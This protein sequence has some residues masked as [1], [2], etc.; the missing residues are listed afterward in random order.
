[1]RYLPWSL[2]MFFCVSS[3]FADKPRDYPI[4]PVPFTAVKVGDGFWLPRMTTSRS[5]FGTPSWTR[6]TTSTS[7]SAP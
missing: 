1:M 7:L 3:L 4:Q 6:K 5:V 2:L